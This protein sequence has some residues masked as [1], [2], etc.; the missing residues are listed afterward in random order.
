MKPRPPARYDR[1]ACDW[2]GRWFPPPGRLA[3]IA[4]R[5]K[6]TDPNGVVVDVAAALA[7]PVADSDADA[8]E[9][10]DDGGTDDDATDADE[11]DVTAE[12]TKA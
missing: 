3:T 7:A 4:E 11:A 6:V 10:L 8:D 1:D 5:V 9:D 12:A 2:R